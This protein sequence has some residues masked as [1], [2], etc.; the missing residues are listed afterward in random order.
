MINNLSVF[1]LIPARGGSRRIPKKNIRKLA[2]KPL[3]CYSIEEAKKS[4]YIDRLILSSDD[5]EIVS[6]AQENG[7]DAP[8]IRPQKFAGD[9]VTDFPV[10]VHAL[11]WLEEHESYIPDIV[12]QLRPTS[13][14][15]TADQIDAAIELL[16]RHSEADSVRTVAEPEQSPYKM[17]RI[18]NAGYLEP[19]LQPEGEEEPFN[20]PN[21]KLPKAYKHVGYVDV[22]WRSTIMEKGQM[23]GKKV[24]PL[25]LEEAYSGI[26]TQQDWEYYEFLI[27]KKRKKN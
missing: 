25:F 18:G 2:G 9:D 22:M 13:P 5:A 26:N 27:E 23:T 14:L 11:K 20:L 4:R 1:A 16:A 15:R 12:V 6:I 10:F 8:F 3:V 17:Y 19:L 24:L 21:A 7:C